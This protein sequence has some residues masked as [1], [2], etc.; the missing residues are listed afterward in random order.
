M[1]WAVVPV[2]KIALGY[3]NYNTVQEQGITAMNMCI[4]GYSINL[5]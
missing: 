2:Y 5:L 3:T 1:W 4:V